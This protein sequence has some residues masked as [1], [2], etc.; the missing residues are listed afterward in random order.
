MSCYTLAAETR[1][2]K[3]RPFFFYDQEGCSLV[4]RV[5]SG[6]SYSISRHKLLFS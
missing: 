5:F 2:G 4:Q 6:D 1:V 3:G